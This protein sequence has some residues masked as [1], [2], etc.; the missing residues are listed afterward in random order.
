MELQLLHV[1]KAIVVAR[2]RSE[3]STDLAAR[4]AVTNLAPRPILIGWTN[5]EP[6]HLLIALN[7]KLDSIL[8]ATLGKSA[9]VAVDV[10]ETREFH[11][12][13]PTE[14]SSLASDAPL[15]IILKWKFAQPIIWQP[16]RKLVAFL[17]KQDLENLLKGTEA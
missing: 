4:L 12:L 10:G 8:D 9:V 14:F 5:G 13:K 11:L 16:S 1:P 2:S 17:Y 3:H 15:L 6:N 7:T